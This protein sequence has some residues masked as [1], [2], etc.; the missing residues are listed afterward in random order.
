MSPPAASLSPVQ[1]DRTGNEQPSSPADGSADAAWLRAVFDALPVA[2]RVQDQSGRLVLINECG[3][4]SMG[5]ELTELIEQVPADTTELRLAATAAS[6]ASTQG[7][8][9]AS[10]AVT[11][12]SAASPGL[13]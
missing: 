11:V 6:A 1:P 13:T 4:R 9:R 12:S 3:A 7:S 5:R 2:V 10:A 8:T